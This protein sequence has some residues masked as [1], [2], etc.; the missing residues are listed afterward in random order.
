MNITMENFYL[1][2][3]NKRKVRLDLREKKIKHEFTKYAG[4][5]MDSY[6][7]GLLHGKIMLF[8]SIIFAWLA[9]MEGEKKDGMELGLSKEEFFHLMDIEIISEF[10][11]MLSRIA[12][13]EN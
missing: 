5:D 13:I 3:T 12:V 1:T 6:Y 8:E 4:M 9:A 2:L 11:L 7:E 10:K